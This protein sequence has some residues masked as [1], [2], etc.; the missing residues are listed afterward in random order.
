MDAISR[1][2]LTRTIEKMGK[3]KEFCEKLGIKNKSR[4]L[5]DQK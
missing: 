1:I 5:T 2:K 4:F 3:N